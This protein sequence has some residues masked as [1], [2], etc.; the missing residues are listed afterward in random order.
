MN[1]RNALMSPTPWLAAGMGLVVALVFLLMGLGESLDAWLAKG[2]EANGFPE[3]TPLPAASPASL[4]ALLIF[5]IG[6]VFAV[7][8]TPGAGRRVML[9]LSGTVILAM[10][11]PVLAL[12]GVLW[13]PF[14]LLISVFWAGVASMVH[15]ASRDRVEALRIAN[16]QNVVPMNTPV[17]PQE[18]RK[19][20]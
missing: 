13:N 3:L 9:L 20:K 10:A 11:S 17:S 19:G 14:I 5:T 18:R 16:E 15:A 7:E 12:W 2:F 6:A 4:V 8:G 1:N